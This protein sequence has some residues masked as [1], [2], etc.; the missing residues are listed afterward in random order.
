MRRKLVI[1][2]FRKDQKSGVTN[3][4][5][6]PEHNRFSLAVIF[7][8][9][10]D[11][12]L[13]VNGSFAGVCG[14]AGAIFPIGNSLVQFAYGKFPAGGFTDADHLAFESFAGCS[15]SGTGSTGHRHSKHSHAYINMSDF[16]MIF[17]WLGRGNP[18]TSKHG[19]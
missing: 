7:I 16:R 1:N 11:I 19:P 9:K 3:A 12:D 17:V 8:E 2:K 18:E 10:V 5:R 14:F 13:T 6:L 15:G 4:T